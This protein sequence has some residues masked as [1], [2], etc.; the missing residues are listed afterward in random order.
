MHSRY[1]PGQ[2]WTSCLCPVNVCILSVG[3]TWEDDTTQQVLSKE[4]SKLR[5]IPYRPQQTGSFYTTE[6]RSDVYLAQIVL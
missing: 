2:Y 3:L 6:S 4:L 5:R 1:A